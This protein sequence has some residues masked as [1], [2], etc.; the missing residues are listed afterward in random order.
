MIATLL[1][2]ILSPVII[3]GVLSYRNTA[4]ILLDKA[5]HHSLQTMENARVFFIE[6]F[7]IQTERALDVFASNPGLGHSEVPLA[8]WHEYRRF[9]PNITAVYFGAADGQIFMSTAFPHTPKLDPRKR[10]WYQ[11]ARQNPGATEWSSVYLDEITGRPVVTAARAVYAADGGLKG[12]IG[13]DVSLYMLSDIVRKIYFEQGGYAVLVDRDGRIIAHPDPAEA[14]KTVTDAWF[15]QIKA[16]PQGVILAKRGGKETFVSHITI[17]GTGWKLVGFIP[18][19]NIEYELAPIKIRTQEVGAVAAIFALLLG[20]IMA[21][22]IA[23]RLRGLVAAMT[24]VQQGDFSARWHDRSNVEFAA[25]GDKFTAMVTTLENLIRQEHEAQQEIARQKEYFAQLFENS[26]ESIAIMDTDDRIIQINHHFTRMFGYSPAEAVGR[27]INDLV[28]PEEL[29]EQGMAVSNSVRGNRI[30]EI[31]TVRKSKDGRLIDV[32]VIGYPII[33]MGESVGGYVIYRDISER[34]EGERRLTHASTHDLL[35]GTFNRRYFEQEMQR[36]DTDD[37]PAAGIIICDIDGLKLVNDTLGHAVGD[38]LLLQAARI[39]RESVPGHAVLCRIGGDEFAILIPVTDETSLQ[40]LADRI[41]AG[42]AADNLRGR[43]YVLSLSLGFAVRGAGGGMDE[44]YREADSRMYRE[45]LH[46][47]ASARSALVK[48]LTEALHARDFITEGHADRLQ[49]LVERLARAVGIPERLIGDLRLLAQFHDIGKVGIPDNIL[50]K[51]GRLTESE[52]KIMRRHSEI[53][54]RIAVASP[55]FHHIA[56]WILKHHEWWNGGGYPLGIKGEDIP[57][58]CR[59]LLIADAFD[60][61]TQDRPYRKAMSTGEALKEIA[62]CKG[63]MFD[64]ELADKF[65]ALFE[66]GR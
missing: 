27:Y 15:D 56:D 39:L 13:I 36:L 59:I 35:T 44:A 22:G 26:P 30:V 16:G 54:Y 64:P 52:K 28:V 3:L 31:E 7:F 5:Q 1:V 19:E 23:A 37:Y 11:Q 14:G 6:N 32:F 4:A 50:F 33:V 46:R 9:H 57:V 63:K 8:E 48:T 65:I 43:E 40:Q 66:N 12:V 20:I 49:Q 41:A 47:S 38:D 45:K 21:S 18:Q 25:I 42:I 61:M 62:A 58:E 60:A 10:P 53:G 51:P 17:P 34:K 55:D 2:L 29:R 24:R